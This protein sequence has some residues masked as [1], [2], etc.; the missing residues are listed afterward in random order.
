MSRVDSSWTGDHRR[1]YSHEVGFSAQPRLFDVTVLKVQWKEANSLTPPGPPVW[2][3][4]VI[5]SDAHI[6]KTSSTFLTVLVSIFPSRHVDWNSRCV[7]SKFCWIFRPCLV[8][9]MLFRG[10]LISGFEATV[11]VPSRKRMSLRNRR[12]KLL[13]EFS[14]VISYGPICQ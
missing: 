3:Q 10:T 1:F 13:L 4:Q 12:E 2:Y 8:Q 11:L 7:I 14:S 6:R 9:E 5:E